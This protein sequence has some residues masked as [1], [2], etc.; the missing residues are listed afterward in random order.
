VTRLEAS[1]YAS[2]RGVAGVDGLR[3]YWRE[4]AALCERAVASSPLSTLIVD[5]SIGDWDQ[6]RRMIL[7]RLA[8]AL[9]PDEPA[10]ETD[11]RR[12]VGTY[13]AGPAGARECSVELRHG[14]LVLQGLLWPDNRLLPK[15]HGAFEAE[16]WPLELHFEEDDDGTVGRIRAVGPAL[17]RG[18]I[19]GVFERV[20]RPEE[21]AP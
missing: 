13:R 1:A 16:S 5:V 6:R 7:D 10:A 15:A 21:V 19:D 18:R 4:H 2:A 9:V 14:G 11:L 8:L 20:I 12:C 17:G 3:A